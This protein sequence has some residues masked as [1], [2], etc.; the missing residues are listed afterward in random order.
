MFK[1]YMLVAL[2][3][4]W[5]NKI[6]TVINVLGL[7]IGLSAALVIFLI[8]QFDYSFDR[9]EKNGNRI[10]RVVSS[11]AFQDYPGNTR[12]VPAPLGEAVK[13]NIDGLEQI[14]NFRYYNVNKLEVPAQHSAMQSV[15]KAQEHVIFA[16]ESYF[17][18]LPYKWLAGSPN[19]ALQGE[20]KVIISETRAKLYFPSLSFPDMIGR[21]IIYDDTITTQ[22]SGVVADFKRQGNT[23][24]NFEEFISL[25]TI[26]NNSGLRSNFHWDVWGSTTS[27]QQLY[28]ELSN[29]KKPEAV[30]AGLKKVFDDNLGADAKKNNYTWT[31]HLQ[32]L[33]DIHFN[34][35]YGD[36]GI[37]IANKTTLASLIFVA[38]FLLV[39]GCIN[40]INLSTA[41]ASKRAKEIGIRKTMGS[42]K[43]QLL[44]QFLSETFII[45]LI[46]S[47]LSFSL[48]PVLLKLFSDFIPE[49]VR[50]S[51][52]DPF[53]ILFLLILV[54]TVSLLAGFYPAAVLSSS[55]PLQVLKNQAY[56]GSART[57]GAWIR[58]TL[59]VA[60]FIIA[61]AFIMGTFL[62]GKQIRFMLD[63]DLGFRKEAIIS[64]NTPYADTSV[65]KR[66][67]LLNEL[68]KIPGINL[69]SLG[70]DVPS[71]FGWWTTTLEYQ[72]RKKEI[73]TVVELKAGDANY[74][75][76]FQIPLLAG[77]YLQPSDTTKEI[78]INES[79]MHFLGF[80]NPH[81]VIGKM[82]KLDDKMVPVVGVM[83][84]FHPHPLNYKIAPLAFCQSV[85]N[86]RKIIVALKPEE[87][88]GFASGGVTG[89]SKENNW[90]EVIAKMKDAFSKTYPQENFDY[91]FFDE[92]IASAYGSQQNISSLLKWATGLTV[93]IS[94]LGL[95]GLVI[96]TTNHRVK[97]IGVRKVLGASVTQIVS[98]LSKDFI[99][100]VAIAFVVATPLA[101]WA[102]H[103]WLDDFAFRTE[104]SWWVF[105][106]SGI[107]MIVIALITLSV[108]TI[109][110]AM[111]NP[112]NSL[113][114]E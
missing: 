98:I 48:I 63:K 40:F 87:P 73:K 2:R 94:C 1:N 69:S 49:G 33:N 45:T 65:S 39:L 61:Q 11:Y 92:S 23:D 46:A 82:V 89:V 6:F 104:I 53:L 37:S 78:L 71:S 66:Y 17:K 111:A 26:L 74:L 25:P 4:F 96:Y 110:A 28:V 13:K 93:F 52:N 41:Q 56:Q 76:L 34:N 5:R 113:R 29:E 88:K 72:D 86:C 35:L 101:W 105:I 95:L 100:L 27:D 77:R 57:R 103:K 9:F 80:Q 91:A 43:Y 30:E 22:V 75:R 36:F 51:L 85:N 81:D 21:K 102:L 114:S 67:F 12:G 68:K 99:K 32:P 42:A 108:Q 44:L 14:V 38:F 59:T 19:T 54:L 58:Q 84:D 10:Y 7:S 60:Q 64:F 90:K 106:V 16:E 20:G 70:H 31:Y 18:M 79:C 15:F 47:I 97:E 55:K 62:V 83:K 112:V 3:N 24:F 8:V 107:G 109:R 50:F